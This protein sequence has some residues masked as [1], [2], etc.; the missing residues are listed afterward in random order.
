MPVARTKYVFLQL[1]YKLKF[2]SK[3]SC[4]PVNIT[5][6]ISTRNVIFKINAFQSFIMVS[7]K[8]IVKLCRKTTK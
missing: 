7:A 4:Y 5:M 6:P 8:L 3:P 1:Q 2:I